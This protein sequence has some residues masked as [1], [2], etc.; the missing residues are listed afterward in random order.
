VPDSVK[1]KSK[2]VEFLQLPENARARALQRAMGYTSEDLRRPRIGIAN[3]WGETSPGHVHLR[4]VADAVKAGVW[5]AGGTPFEFNSF[6]MCPMSVGQHG[7]RYDTPTRDIIA[8][9]VEASTQLHLFDALVMISSCDKNVPGHLLA[10]ARLGLPTILVPGG[11][12][13]S[14]RYQGE[15]LDTTSV[16]RE[17]WAFGAGTPHVPLETLEALEDHACPGAGSCALLGTANTMQCLSEALGLTLPGGGTALATSARRLWIAR[18]SGRRI[19]HLWENE[20][21]ATD[22]LTAKSLKNAIHVLHAIGGSTNAIVHLLALADE[23][24]LEDEINLALMEE[25]GLKTPCIVNVR[26]SGPHTMRDFDET[27]GIPVVMKRISDRLYTNVPTATGR[28]L[29]E[30]LEGIVPRPSP[31][32]R[33]LN[34]PVATKGLAILHGTL[35]SSA[36]VRPT[37]IPREMLAHRGPAIV[38]DSQEAALEGLKNGRVRKGDVVVVRYEGPR[39]GPGLTEVFKVIGYL[40]ALGLE[41]HCALVTDGKISGFAQG[42][43]ICQITPEAALGGPLALVRDDDVIEIDIERKIL[44][45]LLDPEEMVRRRE[46]WRLPPPRV[47]RGFLTLYARMALPASRGA[48][49]DLRMNVQGEVTQ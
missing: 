11:P 39:G 46:A 15:D 28:S 17:C 20:V 31:V 14:G 5:Q 45:L 6:A 21:K 1:R 18:E 38:F 41:R 40:K 19:I 25:A 26:P 12:M 22:I 49:L 48:G 16:D 24:G 44:N 27:G 35:A 13:D 2:N 42:P 4:A 43:F 3:T 47:T 10:A 34:Q 29:R 23:L 8:A 9:A 7:I 30:N 33:D 37:V 32:I 36:V